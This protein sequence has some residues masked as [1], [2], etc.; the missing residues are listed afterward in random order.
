M[1][2]LRPTVRPVTTP[3]G[4]PPLEP[5]DHLDQ[6]T[7]HARYLAMPEGVR[8][9]LV[10]GVVIMWS[11]PGRWSRIGL[12][13]SDCH[14]DVQ[15]WVG[16]FKAETPGTRALN[17]PTDILG[18]E[19][20]VQPDTCLIIRPSHGGQTREQDGYMVGAPELVIEVASSSVS[21]DLH[22]KRRSYERAGVKEYLVVALRE[23][24]VH[25]FVREDQVFVAL[26]PEAD[27]IFR[28]R[29]FP[30]LWLDPQALLQGR[31]ARLMEVL[32]AGLASQEHAAL[33]DRLAEA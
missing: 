5:G 7:F 20:E 12:P 32:R 21:Y 26:P 27:G 2:T 9:E 24:E 14:S 11:R 17:N 15:T 30:G 25:W 10:Q 28:S 22:S 6:P 16:I 31:T 23:Q 1:T 33:V 29:V 18:P 19:D 4:L 8:A 13:H 3:D